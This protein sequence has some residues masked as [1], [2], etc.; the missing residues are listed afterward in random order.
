MATRSS[1]QRS[2]G[3]APER[4]G[5]A[6]H[7]HCDV[8]DRTLFC[9][10]RVDCCHSRKQSQGSSLLGMLGPERAPSSLLSTHTTDS[11]PQQNTPLDAGL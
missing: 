1:S 4:P 7:A 9:F 6:S 11:A 10:P 3:K 8:R 2:A 5:A